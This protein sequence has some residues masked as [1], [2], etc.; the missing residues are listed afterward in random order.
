MA[1]KQ[2][3]WGSDDDDEEEE[4]G[5]GGGSWQVQTG[6]D[7]GKYPAQA[8]DGDWGSPGSLTHHGSFDPS[9]Q[10]M[11]AERQQGSQ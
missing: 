10:N 2:K 7:G 4:E 11:S 3:R 6:S 8:P 1:C 9:C 5:G